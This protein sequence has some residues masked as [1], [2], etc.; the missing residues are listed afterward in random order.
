MLPSRMG[1]P[2]TVVREGV[3]RFVHAA[4]IHL[5]SP[6]QN[7]ALQ[8]TDKITKVRRA[9]R[10]AFEDMIDFCID[11]EVSF[12][13]LAGDLYDGDNANMQVAVF[14]RQQLRKL[15]QAGIRVI[16][17][18]GNHDAAN[19]ITSDLGLPKN[20]HIF[21]EDRPETVRF[22]ELRVAFHGQSFRPG[23]ITENLA[24]G[25]PRPV[26]G[27]LNIG[28]LHTS[29]AGNALHDPYAPCRL[30]DLTSRGYAYWALGHIHKGGVLAN[31][32]WVV[33]SGNIQGRDVRETGP[34]GCFLVQT[35]DD[36]VLSAQHVAF[37]VVRWHQADVDLDGATRQED[38]IERVRASLQEARRQAQGRPCVVRIRFTGRTELHALIGAYPNKLRHMFADLANEIAMDEIW[39][40]KIRNDTQ[41]ARP[42]PADGGNETVSE[43]IRLMHE[44]A[45]DAA[46][47]GP[48]LEKELTP[49][50]AKLPEGLKELPALD[51]LAD[52]GRVREALLRLEPR[53]AARLAG[54]EV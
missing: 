2:P 26:P 5:D 50:K 40:E 52:P 10:D 43:L 21:R 32:P 38:L 53:I 28:V 6:L 45:S 14:F 47:I 54:E 44:I 36:R 35:E 11:R 42:R 16:I 49:L 7:L 30:E 20:T 8:D 25:Y 19:P 3:M 12:L 24:A 33:Y 15:E 22:E 18:K 29:L 41:P 13:V 17:K 31:A 34:K 9:C 4:D 48:A 23:Q 37:D 39:I 1:T 51:L 46:S 27:W